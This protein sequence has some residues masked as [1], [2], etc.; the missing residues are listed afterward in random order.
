[1]RFIVSRSSYRHRHE[2]GSASDAEPSGWSFRY[3]DRITLSRA[4]MPRRRLYR[5]EIVRD[6]GS[7]H[8]SVHRDDTG[9]GSDAPGL[10]FIAHVRAKNFLDA[11]LSYFGKLP[12][13]D[14]NI[15]PLVLLLNEHGYMTQSTCSGNRG[16]PTGYITLYAA[17]TKSARRLMRA[18]GAIEDAWHRDDWPRVQVTVEVL[19]RHWSLLEQGEW[20]LR[21]EFSS[22]RRRPIR[23]AEYANVCE[24]LRTILSRPD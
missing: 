19:C 18:C 1:M 17:S 5:F 24:Q 21:L 10:K 2:G 20:S 23:A 13:I 9:D 14:R 22:L 3:P 15:R 7:R 12:P 6:V 16:N 11:H 4:P 8:Y